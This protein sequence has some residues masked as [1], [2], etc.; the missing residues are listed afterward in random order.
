MR[1]EKRPARL[2]ACGIAAAAAA[3]ACA[4]SACG[5]SSSSPAAAG[6]SGKATS[7]SSAVVAKAESLVAGY[8]R[9]PA[10]IPL[11]TPLSAAAAKGKTVVWLECDLSQCTQIGQ[12]VAAAAA[13]IGWNLKVVDYSSANPATLVAAMNKA[14]QY[15]PVAVAL[16][17]LPEAV[18]STEI[19]AYQKAGVPILTAFVGP[20]TP[21]ATVPVNISSADDAQLG[22]SMLGNWLIADS[23]GSAHAL[24]LTSSA[25]PVF[26]PLTTD[27]RSVM[28]GCSGCSLTTLDA[29]VGQIDAGQVSSLV[30][31]ALKRDP[32]IKYVVSADS[33]FIDGLPSAIAAAGLSSSV[34]VVSQWGDVQ[35][36][37]AV[38]S[39][40]EAATSGLASEYSGWLLVDAAARLLAKDPIPSAAQYVLPTQLVTSSN[41]GSLGAPSNSYNFPADYAAQFKTLWHVG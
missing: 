3:L 34:K 39:G 5:T 1:Q 28:S 22:A 15:D 21:T 24:V 16:S 26:G 2:A 11:T 17:G 38:A 6:S 18:W 27:L 36:I 14:L 7:S 35:A 20:E 32:T 9:M 41:V 4:L 29:T 30:V 31:S 25:F 19:P 23:G 40:Q 37:S 33:L 8:E 10:K 12:G 13:A